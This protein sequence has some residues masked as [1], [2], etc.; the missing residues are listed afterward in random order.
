MGVI[1]YNI[2]RVFFIRNSLNLYITYKD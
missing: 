1:L 2:A